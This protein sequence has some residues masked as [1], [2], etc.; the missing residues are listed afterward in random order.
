MS[1]SVNH[2]FSWL[3]LS[4]L[5]FPCL[6]RAL[7]FRVSMSGMIVY[8]SDVARLHVDALKPEIVGNQDFPASSAVLRASH[9]TTHSTLLQSIS[10]RRLRQACFRTAARLARCRWQLT[11][12]RWR[13]RLDSSLLGWRSRLWRLQ[14]TTLSWL[15]KP[16]IDVEG[17]WRA[18][19][20]CRR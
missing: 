16:P 13:R 19:A 2:S 5:S 18:I 12:P 15:P 20:V 17:S 1:V 14:S 4:S 7:F 9:L 10:P 3:C 8:L 6:V 11:L